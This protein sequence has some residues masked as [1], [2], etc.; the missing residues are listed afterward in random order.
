MSPESRAEASSDYSGIYI[1]KTKRSSP[2][3]N[4]DVDNSDEAAA[5][6]LFKLLPVQSHT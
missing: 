6:D 1:R 5:A 3:E 2:Q 4:Y